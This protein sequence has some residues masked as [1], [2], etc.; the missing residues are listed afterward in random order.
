MGGLEKK[1]VSGSRGGRTS[2]FHSPWPLGTERSGDGAGMEL[3]RAGPW[4]PGKRFS[5]W[6]ESCGDAEPPKGS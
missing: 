2:D 1:K 3:L 4:R 5:L 6:K